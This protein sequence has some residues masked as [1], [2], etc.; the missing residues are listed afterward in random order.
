MKQRIVTILSIGI[1]IGSIIGSFASLHYVIANRYIQY[2]LFRITAYTFQKNLNA[3]VFYFAIGLLMLYFIWFLISK[4]INKKAAIACAA[5]TF[6]L[7]LI[8]TLLKTFTA[9]TLLS[10]IKKFADMM[11]KIFT[12]EDPFNYLL[13]TLERY[14]I[15]VII[16]S[17][18]VVIAGFLCWLLA[19]LKWDRVSKLI[20]EKYIKRTA[21]VLV[22]FL[23]FLNLGIVIDGKIKRPEGPN[24][25]ILLI[26]ALRRDHLG[27]YGYHRNT[28]PNIDRF[29]E[30]AV[31]FKK[32]ISPSPYTYASV[33]T[34]FTSLYPSE[35][36]VV[37]Y[38]YKKADCLNYEFVTLAEALREKGYITGAFT[39]NLLVCKG[40]LFDQGFDAFN[41]SIDLAGQIGSNKLRAPKLNEKALKWI[42]KNRQ[43]PFFIY[44]HYMDVHAPYEPPKPYDSLFKSAE[45]INEDVDQY[46]GEIR[47]TDYHIA[48]FLKKLEE[49]NLLNNS[50]I[51]I[52]A[53]HGEAFREHG[54]TDHGNS[55]YNEEIEIPLI[56]RFP[57]S[58]TCQGPKQ[59]RTELIDLSATILHILDCHLPYSNDGR[60][61]LRVSDNRMFFSEKL[62][63][64]K[65]DKRPLEIAMIKNDFKA[66]YMVD[67]EKVTELYDL[68]RDG[69]EKE[70]LGD[71]DP[72]KAKRFE[73]EIRSW[74]EG[75]LEK[76][77]EIG[78]KESLGTI[79]DE[80]AIEKLRALG[81]L[82]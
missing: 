38:G 10:G 82:Q 60:N 52:T 44:L 48:R 57:E 81:Y 51:V 33:A 78:L 34:L 71:L 76:R 39:A 66:I 40:L 50:I 46:D 18:I 58:I 73:E 77:K 22:A 14:K 8:H 24:V 6:I 55:V 70:N 28:S 68:K 69:L 62:W 17:C 63:A 20:K 79:T 16:F 41:P 9:Y 7:L 59:D 27:V 74:R 37:R 19:R 30:E 75:K 65:N 64:R 45:E 13:H 26:D 49:Y 35:H 61:L 53:D 23:I 42:H 2:K 67:E 43:K 32:P 56:V 29:S 5:V 15:V 54:F 80:R 72:H 31:V 12:G 4:K 1:I 11:G 47:F 3:N 21:F 25:I 36:G